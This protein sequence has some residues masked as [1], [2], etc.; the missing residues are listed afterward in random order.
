[1]KKLFYAL[2]YYVFLAVFWIGAF[3][4]NLCTKIRDLLG[5]PPCPAA[6]RQ[7]LQARMLWYL[8]CLDRLCDMHVDYVDWPEDWAAQLSGALVVANHPSLIDAPMIIARS[9]RII[10]LYKAALERSLLWPTTARRA[11]YLSNEGGIDSVREAV[12]QLQAGETLL[13]FP[14]GTRTR[15]TGLGE[16]VPGG[17]LIAFRARC[18]VQTLTIE[19]STPLLTK[20]GSTIRPPRTPIEVKVR[21]GERFACAR[22]ETLQAFNRRLRAYFLEQ[23]PGPPPA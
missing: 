7:L 15:K 16:F 23:V 22:G 18:P 10:C 6:F 14:E 20:E 13:L 8:G 12:E 21:W 19:F 5:V 11:G 3:L 1:M 17:A 2:G 4:T 9:P